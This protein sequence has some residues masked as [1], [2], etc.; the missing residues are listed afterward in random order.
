VHG[1]LFR[2][3][4]NTWRSHPVT[5]SGYESRHGAGLSGCEKGGWLIRDWITGRLDTVG[6]GYRNRVKGAMRHFW[7]I[8][9]RAFVACAENCFGKN[10]GKI[11]REIV[12]RKIQKIF[13]VCEK[14]FRKILSRKIRVRN[15]NFFNKQNQ[16]PAFNPV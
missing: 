11:F 2:K 5:H 3:K 6:S 12:L 4:L 16:N 15:S 8:T 9:N 7:K 1:F 13:F 14:F 10:P